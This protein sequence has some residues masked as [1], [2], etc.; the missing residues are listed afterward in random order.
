M[1]NG[2]E[3]D[4]EKRAVLVD[5]VAA[6]AQE[7]SAVQSSSDAQPPVPVAAGPAEVPSN[8]GMDDAVKSMVV[9]L[10]REEL[11]RSEGERAAIEKARDAFFGD[12]GYKDLA[13]YRGAITG[14]VDTHGVPAVAVADFLRSVLG[15]AQP[16]DEDERELRS[17][18]L[19]PE[20]ARTLAKRLRARARGLDD[21]ESSG[22]G[23]LP[24]RDGSGQDELVARLVA[25]M[26]GKPA[27]RG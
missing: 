5:T 8:G 14:M 26:F 3:K 21:N 22:R 16:A 6:S 18:G 4:K 12:E 10:V 23:P 7:P 19:P 17:A 27:V 2:E 13:Q 20:A 11:Q 9:T 25:G 1:S 24:G 15:T